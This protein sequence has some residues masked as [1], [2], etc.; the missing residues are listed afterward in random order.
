MTTDRAH[1]K[2][3]MGA[4]PPWRCVKSLSKIFPLTENAMFLAA[5]LRLALIV[6]PLRF[7]LRLVFRPKTCV[8]SQG[9][10]IF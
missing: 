10:A 5:K 1:K 9:T 7:V 2:S 4:K 3:A 8:F 6:M